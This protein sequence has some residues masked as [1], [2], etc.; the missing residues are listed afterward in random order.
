MKGY[1]TVEVALLFPVVFFIYV[2]ILYIGFYQYDRCLLEQD[3]MRVALKGSIAQRYGNEKALQTMKQADMEREMQKYL[4]LYIE[5][6]EF[7]AG[8]GL[9][10]VK[11]DASLCFPFSN[12]L[13][14]FENDIWEI[15]TDVET[16]GQ[17]PVFYIRLC[18]R[19]LRG[20]KKDVERG[21][22]EELK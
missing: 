2:F 16:V 12:L 14:G 4:G 17:D 7:S 9:V 22:G 21:N 20:E 8:R 3:C 1:F 10:S 19:L 6:P 5:E 11:M 13:L 15:H 18:N